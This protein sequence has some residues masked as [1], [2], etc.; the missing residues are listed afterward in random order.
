MQK[1][2]DQGM[3]GPEKMQLFTMSLAGL[4]ADE[5]RKA[6]SLYIRNAIS[7]LRAMEES[8]AAMG[9]AQMMFLVSPLFWPVLYMQRRMINAQRRFSAERIR[10]AIHVWRD[11]LEGEHFD[12]RPDLPLGR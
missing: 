10:N 6:K 12:F 8:A 9:C 4:S 1:E 5:I 2:E 11:D 7:E 3:L